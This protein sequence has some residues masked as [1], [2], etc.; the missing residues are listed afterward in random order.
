MP[1]LSHELM[2]S[3]VAHMKSYLAERPMNLVFPVEVTA[4]TFAVA[5]FIEHAV[6]VETAGA[7]A[8]FILLATLSTLALLEHWLMVMSIQEA[9]LWKW[10]TKQR[11]PD[12]DAPDPAD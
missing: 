10:K 9:A 6:S 1:N 11:I 12:S 2:P 5:C 7:Q 3:R 8:G 4:L